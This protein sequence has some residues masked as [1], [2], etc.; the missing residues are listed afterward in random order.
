M[1]SYLLIFIFAILEGEIYY[2]KVCADAVAG[3]LHWLP[4]LLAGALGATS[5]GRP[6]GTLGDAGFFSFQTLKPLNCYGGGLALVR[7]ASLA[8]R[9]RALAEQERWPEAKRV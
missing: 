5:D 8:S 6:V 9:V 2:S 1:L 4:V 3:K 7:A